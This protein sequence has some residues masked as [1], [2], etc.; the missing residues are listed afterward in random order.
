LNIQAGA[1]INDG[2]AISWRSNLA[3]RKA[4]RCLSRRHIQQ[5]FAGQVKSRS[6]VEHGGEANH[7]HTNL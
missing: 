3:V 1:V 7:P 4:S 2:A 5:P 6:T